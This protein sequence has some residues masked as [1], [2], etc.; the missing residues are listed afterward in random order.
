[1]AFLLL[2]LIQGLIAGDPIG[3]VRTALGQV[4][5]SIL[6]M[7]GLVGVTDLLVRITDAASA[8]VLAGAPEDLRLLVEQ[9]GT[10]AALATG[11]IA[12]LVLL[13]VF[14]LGALLVWMELVVRSALVHLLLAFAPLVLAARVWPATRGMFR[15][16]CELGVALIVSKFVVSL[17][18]ALGAAALAGGGSS[19]EGSGGL[20]LAGLLGG[21]TLMGLAAFT[22]FVVL[23]LLPIVETAMVAHGISRSPV[24]GARLAKGASA[25]PARLARMAGGAA[26]AA[27]AAGLATGR[28]TAGAAAP[29]IGSAAASATAAA[30]GSRRHAGAGPGRGSGPP[31]GGQSGRPKTRPSAGTGGPR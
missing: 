22:P 3:M 19:T 5:L 7:V 16:L 13:I 25:Y 1:V 17:T 14:L 2:T 28:G 6:G 11:G 15:R 21:A 29:T 27:G 8:A 24:Q 10:T 12:G 31:A 23:R 30:S 20:S 9:Y 18:L 4:P 26:L